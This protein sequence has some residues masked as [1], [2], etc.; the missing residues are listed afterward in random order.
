[1]IRHHTW[2]KKPRS[3]R[4]F[5]VMLFLLQKIYSLFER[6]EFLIDTWYIPQ[7]KSVR[8]CVRLI[9]VLV[10]KKIASGLVWG[11]S[12]R[13]VP[14]KKKQNAWYQRALRCQLRGRPFHPWARRLRFSGEAHPGPATL[15][16]SSS[17][18][19]GAGLQAYVPVPGTSGRFVANCGVGPSTRGQGDSASLV[20]PTQD[21]RR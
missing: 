20:K 21:Q 16:Q 1:M 15:T 12:E 10:W 6:S 11:T 19:C 7:K 5:V 2:H 9:L 18:S 17:F 4:L 8:V 3:V 14:A 13:L